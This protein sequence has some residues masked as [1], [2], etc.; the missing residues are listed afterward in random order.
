MNKTMPDWVRAQILDGLSKLLVLRLQ[1]APPADTVKAVGTV[2][3][4]ALTPNTWYFNR[5]L[6]F[7]RLPEAFSLLIQETDRWPPP[8]Q[9]IERIPPRKEHNLAGLLEHKT[10]PLTEEQLSRNKLRI[11]EM[12]QFLNRT[13]GKHDE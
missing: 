1:G 6:D 11:R 4:E 7:K 2:W 8:A 10:P 9:L 12:L 13:K 3:I 5:E